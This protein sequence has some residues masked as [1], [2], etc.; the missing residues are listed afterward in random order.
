MFVSS[1]ARRWQQEAE[2]LQDGCGQAV[3]APS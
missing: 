1:K 2:T 3:L